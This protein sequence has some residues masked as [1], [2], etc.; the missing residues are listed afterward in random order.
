MTELA[1]LSA[2]LVGLLGGIHCAAMCGGIVSAISF[3]GITVAVRPVLSTPVPTFHLAYN[4]GR[5]GSYTLAGAVAGLV[6][7]LGTGLLDEL[8]PIRTMLYLL[9]SF[10]LLAQ[11]M[12]LAGVWRGLAALERAGGRLWAY[13]QP[14]SRPL[15]PV[16]SAPKALALGAIWGWLPCGM[17]Y[18]V[19][20]LALASGDATS[21]AL[22]MFAFGLGTLPNLLAMAIAAERIRP[23]LKNA[24]VRFAAG[25][26]V[27]GFGVIGLVRALQPAH[28]H[29]S[30]LSLHGSDTHVRASHTTGH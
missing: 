15:L 28:D 9:A 11:G 2:F 17:V 5:I 27:M 19:L 7:A 8:L 29:S 18:S 23:L 16:D 6:G 30:S 13:I 12:Y 14:W 26:L 1:V 25:A 22:T 3:R 20:A 24:R 4:A 10:M 21:G